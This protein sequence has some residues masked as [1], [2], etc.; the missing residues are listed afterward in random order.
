[1]AVAAN[2][3]VE[4]LQCYVGISEDKAIGNS[5]RRCAIQEKVPA[6]LQAP[7]RG[8]LRAKAARDKAGGLCCVLESFRLSLLDQ[9]DNLET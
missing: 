5:T 7:E 9:V 1:V 6:H 8:L 2:V 4:R 3:N